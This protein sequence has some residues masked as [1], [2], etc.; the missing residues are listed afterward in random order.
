MLKGALKVYDES[1]NH[2][3]MWHGTASSSSYIFEDYFKM[4]SSL[5]LKKL[6]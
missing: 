5:K 1:Y 6:K 3:T 2:V 4:M